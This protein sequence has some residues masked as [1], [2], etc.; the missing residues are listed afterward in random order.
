MAVPC[1]NYSGM[2]AFYI[3]SKYTL[4]TA[5]QPTNQEI[6]LTEIK[7][8]RYA[9]LTFNGWKELKDVKPEVEKL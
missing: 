9:V 7:S 6:H 1:L 5:P 4:Q 2:F 8:G 3:P